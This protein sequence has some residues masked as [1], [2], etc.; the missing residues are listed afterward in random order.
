MVANLS[1]ANNFKLAH[2]EKAENWEF[3]KAARFF[4][5][6]GFFLTVSPE[7][8]Q[9]V[10]KHACENNKVSP[11]ELV[12]FSAS[13]WICRLHFC[14]SF[15]KHR[16]WPHYHSLTFCLEMNRKRHPSLKP[17]HSRLADVLDVD[18]EWFRQRVC[19]K[20]RWSWVKCPNP[21]R[22]DPEWSSS[23]KAQNRPSSPLKEK[24][25]NIQWFPLRAKIL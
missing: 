14:V 8:I 3:I 10:A 13:P 22:S 17:M 4:Y 20:L 16:C 2:V 24:W 1:A 21:I 25:L 6:S 11:L 19:Q 12:T 15:S 18:A 7:T 23:P 5:I 9:V